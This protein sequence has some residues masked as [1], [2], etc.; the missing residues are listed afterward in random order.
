[1]TIDKQHVE[2]NWRKGFVAFVGAFAKLR[3]ATTSFGH[4]RLPVRREEFVSHWT[5]FREI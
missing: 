4:V 3:N 2:E 5:D 1:M